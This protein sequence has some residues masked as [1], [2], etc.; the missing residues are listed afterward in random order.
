MLKKINNIF[1]NRDNRIFIVAEMSANHS[2]NIKNAYKI[3]DQAKKIGVD[4]IKVQLYKAN[5]ITINSKKNDFKIKNSSWKKFNTL[6]KLYKKAETPYE[7][8]DRLKKYCNKKDLI[9]FSSVFDLETVDLLE[10]KKCPIYKIA[11]PEI[12]DIPLLKKVAKTKKPVIISSGLASEKDL[13]LA[14]KTLKENK[15]K[16]IAILKCTSSYPAPLSELNLSSI[17]KIKKKYKTIVGFSDHSVNKIAPSIAISY[18]AKIIE[19]HINL[20]KN[21]KSVDGFFSLN[22]KDFREMVKNIRDT[23]KMI[24]TEEI[25]VSKSSKK[26]LVGRKSIYVIKNVDKN[27]VFT[28]KNIGSIRP[29][30][31]AHPKYFNYILGKKSKRKL[32]LGQRMKISFV[33]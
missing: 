23:E 22:I 18:G 25:R 33:K 6:Y 1:N 14:I 28:K 19:K 10:K 20:E 5:K 17:K 32:K 9:I 29:S 7:W 2:N 24:G 16:K 26:N 12:T 3:I 27:E 15:C 30:F 8:Y 4:A 13:D 31:G 11:S 21:K